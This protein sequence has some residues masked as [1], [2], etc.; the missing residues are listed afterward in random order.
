MEE[1]FKRL[2]IKPK[3]LELYKTAFSHSSYVNEHKVKSNYERLEFLGDAVLDL[4]MADYLYTH[5]KETEGEM[6][7]VRANYVCE[8]AN[9][10]YASDLGLQKYILVG[11]GELKDGPSPKKAI[12]ADIFEALM[13][14]IYLDLGYATVRNVILKIVVPYI[15]NPDITFF[16]D[17]KSSLQEYVQTEQ[18]SLEYVVT[19]E[20]GPAH[21]KTFT[22]DVMIDN[23]VYGTGV[24]PSK[25]EAEQEAAKQALEKLAIKR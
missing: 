21:N 11:N 18:R 3:N 4:V 9:F 24:G 19:K 23:I 13:G 2:S 20:E 15:E 6:T 16:S 1:L 25:K 12:V 5:Y 14:A 10:S 17:Y 22:T 8:N 7:K